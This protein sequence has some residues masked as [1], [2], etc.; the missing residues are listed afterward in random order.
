MQTCMY[1][2]SRIEFRYSKQMPN[3]TYVR[4]QRPYPLHLDHPCTR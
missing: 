1:C 2:G 3:G 4:Y